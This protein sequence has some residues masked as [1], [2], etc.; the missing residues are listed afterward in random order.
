MNWY[1]VDKNYVKY[2]TSIDEK[3]GYVEYGD[4]MKLHVGII[5]DVN[6][7]KYYVPIS[8]PKRKHF[9]MSNSVDLFA[10]KGKGYY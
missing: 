2:L 4:R 1:V 3:V 9:R 10:A 6:S 8:S 5:L 7:I